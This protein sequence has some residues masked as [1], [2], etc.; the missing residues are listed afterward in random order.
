MASLSQYER[1][2]LK[3]RINAGLEAARTRGRIGGRPKAID[4]EK[5]DQIAKCLDEGISKISICRTFGVK[6]TT[7]YNY[8]NRRSIHTE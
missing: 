1:A 6:R 3:E 2:L 7:L 8:V 4:S 5:W